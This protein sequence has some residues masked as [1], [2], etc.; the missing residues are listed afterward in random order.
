[1]AYIIKTNF[2]RLLVARAF[3]RSNVLCS[4]EIQN[5]AMIIKKR[6]RPIFSQYGPNK[7]VQEH[8]FTFARF[9]SPRSLSKDSESS[10]VTTSLANW[11]REGNLGRVNCAKTKWR[12]ICPLDSFDKFVDCIQLAEVEIMLWRFA[13]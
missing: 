6:T 7:L 4:E 8:L 5:I 9:R 12:K 11:P 10:L 13:T 2:C 1:M 3:H